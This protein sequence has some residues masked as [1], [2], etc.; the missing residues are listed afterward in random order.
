MSALQITALVLCF[1]IPSIGW[2]LLFRQ[3]FRFTR[4]FRSGQPDPTRTDQPA[5]RTMTL[6]REFL[7]HTRMARLPWVSIAHWFTALSFF[8]LFSTLVNAFFQLVWADFRLPLIGH[9]PPFEWLVELLAWGGLL[10]IIFLIVVRQR[11]HPRSAAGSGGRR[12]RFF[13]STWWQA[14][15]VEFTILA[16]TICILSLRSQEAALLKL[17]SP[18]ESIGLHFPLT[19]WMSGLWGNLSEPWLRESIYLVAMIK[20][21]VSFAWMIT[22]ALQPTMGVAWHRFLAFFNIWFKR[23]ADGRTSLGALQPMSIDGKPWPRTSRGSSCSTSP[24]APSAAAAS[25]SAPRGTPTSPSPPSCS[26]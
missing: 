7:G 3:V 19:G 16:V 9:F 6:V 26:S 8:V 10:G 15:Y 12:S 24:P 4:V 2:L 22:I 17:T 14:Y 18:G 21:L 11:Q 25:R 5:R 1:V 23:N 13:G 20:I